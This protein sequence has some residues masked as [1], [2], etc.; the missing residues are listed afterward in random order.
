MLTACVGVILCAIGAASAP[1]HLARTAA[2][3][4]ATTEVE[5]KRVVREMF[6][7]FGRGDKAALDAIFADTL[8]DTN[9]DGYTATKAEL[10]ASVQPRPAGVDVSL[11]IEDARVNRYGSVA[12]MAYTMV[13][14]EEFH[15]RPL[16]TR[17]RATDTFVRQGQ[18]WRMIARQEVLMPAERVAAP[19]DARV[20]DA[21]LGEYSLSPAV[22]FTVTRERDRLMIQRTGERRKTELV[23]ES[24]TVFFMRRQRGERQFVRDAAGR[25]THLVIRLADGQEIGAEKIR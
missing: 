12:V 20:Y 13:F 15:G 14:A 25:V 1:D 3:S 11:Q 19:V 24:D 6:D 7:A 17:R 16:R 22:T 9:A 23:P 5:L 10:L 21:Y 8:L 2:T 18:R 4:A